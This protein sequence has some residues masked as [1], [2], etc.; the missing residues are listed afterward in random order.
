MPQRRDLSDC[1]SFL[2][3]KKSLSLSQGYLAFFFYSSLLPFFVYILTS[4]CENEFYSGV[5]KCGT[6][7]MVN[8]CQSRVYYTFITQ[9]LEGLTTISFSKPQKVYKRGRTVLT[10]RGFDNCIIHT[11]TSQRACI[12]TLKRFSREIFLIL[13]WGWTELLYNDAANRGKS[14]RTDGNCVCKK[15][16]A[17]SHFVFD[18]IRLLYVFFRR[19]CKS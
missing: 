6:C 13:W 19:E 4:I 5:L 3:T 9:E 17:S 1:P 16:Y 10:T 2:S 12:R 11:H 7:T 14:Q 15:E 8:E 18:V